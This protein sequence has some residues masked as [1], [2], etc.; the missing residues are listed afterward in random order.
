MSTALVPRTVRQAFILSAISGLHVGAFA[1]ARLG[2]LPQLALPV[3]DVPALAAD[4]K[5]P[6]PTVVVRPDDF[7]AGDYE[8][9]ILEKPDVY[10]PTFDERSDAPVADLGT[11]PGAAG[12]G[13]RAGV[14]DLRAPDVRTRGRQ[15]Q[16]LIDRCYPA[17]SR[18]RS[19]EGQVVARI[20]IGADGRLLSWAV[21]EGSGFP[22][23]DAAM[24]CVVRRLE[25]VAGRRDGR[26]VEAA[27]R[28]PITFR[29]D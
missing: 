14:A 19:E 18:R 11:H 25:F 4:R 8:R 5:P 20:V 21:E 17:A 2:L 10:I 1:V 7:R 29:L 9:E 24:D 3:I 27:A 15:V 12:A 22:R 16:S 13:R 6:K 23:L 26:A 28:L